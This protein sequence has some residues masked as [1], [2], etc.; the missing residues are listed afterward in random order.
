[1]TRRTE[2]LG[3]E[4]QRAMQAILAEGLADPRIGGLITVTGVEVT[5]NLATAVI[6]VSILPEARE[7]LTMHGLR[8]A[9]A[10]IRREAGE[11]I[12]ARRLPEFVFKLDRRLKKQA[13]VLAAIAEASRER[14]AGDTPA[15][16]TESSV[17]PETPADPHQ[18][19]PR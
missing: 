3:T 13:E 18:E 11:R 15:P 8:A 12:N 16:A 2:Q 14:A 5:P 6:S 9:A 10:F 19:T 4:I 17:L 1:M 7:D